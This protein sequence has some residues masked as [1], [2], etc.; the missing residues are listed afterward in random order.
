MHL[1]DTTFILAS[2]CH[3]S[4]CMDKLRKSGSCCRYVGHAPR[5][6]ISESLRQSFLVASS[7]SHCPSVKPSPSRRYLLVKEAC[8]HL[9]LGQKSAST[10]LSCYPSGAVERERVCVC[11]AEGL[12]NQS[13]LLPSDRVDIFFVRQKVSLL[14]INRR[15]I[16]NV[17]FNF[18]NMSCLKRLVAAHHRHC[19]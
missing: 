7:L 17:V 1:F 11:A 6:L 19:R 9:C 16:H 4:S 2:G 5:L 3:V 15:K 14:F 18:L 12:L 8:F 10:R 13:D